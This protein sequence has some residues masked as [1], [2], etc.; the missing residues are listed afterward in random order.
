MKQKNTHVPFTAHQFIIKGMLRRPV[1]TILLLII[2]FVGMFGALLLCRQID[3]LQNNWNISSRQA[4]ILCI[5]TNANGRDQ[6]NLNLDFGTVDSLCNGEFSSWVRDVNALSI[7][8]LSSP[9]ESIL[10]RIL[11]FESDPLLHKASGVKITMSNGWSE[12]VFRTSEQVCLVPEGTAVNMGTDGG[13]YI[14]LQP[15]NEEA[16]TL[17]VIGVISNGPEKTYYIPFFMKNSQDEIPLLNVSSCSF[18]LKNAALLEESKEMLFHHFANPK[19]TTVTTVA[20]HGLMINDEAY[21]TTKIN[22][23]QNISMMRFLLPVMILGMGIIGFLVTLLSSHSRKTEFS[24]MRCLG[25][26]RRTVF[27]LIFEEHLFITL[28]AAILTAVVA[29]FLLS[30]SVS[31]L[32]LGSALCI[33]VTFLTGCTI[34]VAYVTSI[35]TMKLSKTEG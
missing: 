22:I 12:D 27:A 1:L 15:F 17:R 35:N 33:S 19:E 23:T 9:N 4:D 21:Q 2:A 10:R 24:I 6:D 34:A 14:T 29:A 7:R 18:Y 20:R 8:P 5:I 26:R 16:Q 11:S 31:L 28:F 3:N 32:A 13:Y 25:I 30:E